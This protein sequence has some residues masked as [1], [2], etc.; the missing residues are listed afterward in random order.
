MSDRK[1]DKMSGIDIISYKLG[2]KSVG[3]GAGGGS[4]DN[5]SELRYVTFMSHDG[6]VEL[7]KK[8]VAV[9][10]DCADPIARGIFDTP[11]KESTAQY[12][13]SFVGWATTPNGAWDEAALDAVTA[14]R[15]VYAAYAAAVRYYTITFYD[16]DGTTVLKTQTLAYGAMPSYTPVKTGYTFTGWTPALA[17]VTGNASYTAEWIAKVDFSSLTW[18]QIASY[19]ESGE[20]ANVFEIGATKSFST[21]GGKTVIAKIIGFNHDDLADG[22]GKAGIT[23]ELQSSF[24]NQYPVTAYTAGSGNGAS[25]AASI[26]TYQSTTWGGS[27]VRSAWNNTGAYYPLQYTLPTD[28]VNVIKSVKKKVVYKGSMT[29][30]NDKLWLISISEL[31]FTDGEAE[32]DCYEAYTSGKTS[33]VSYAELKKTIAGTACAYRTRS[34][35]S[36]GYDN[37]TIS[38]TG[39]RETYSQGTNAL[40]TYPCFCI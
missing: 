29:T 23:L 8:A 19:A 4:G 27:D 33:G 40:G 37:Q 14:D 16:D 3:G 31:G 36:Y 32:G 39:K 25:F 11:T 21:K 26:Q 6:T 38:T 7:G 20:A 24:G 2:Q 10:D 12:N 28:L 35:Y 30:Y 9:G 34:K 15:T 17:T 13:Y 5:S 18:A 22:S 1:G